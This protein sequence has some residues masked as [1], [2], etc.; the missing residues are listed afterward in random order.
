MKKLTLEE[1]R[2]LPVIRQG[3]FDNVV[4]EESKLRVLHSRM[5]VT[6][7][8]P[9]DNQITVQTYDPDRAQWVIT[10]QYQAR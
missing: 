5:T 8:A 3:H 2:N 6:D 7:G 4:M 10:Q 1:I 9:Y